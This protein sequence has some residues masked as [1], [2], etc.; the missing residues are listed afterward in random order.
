M[1]SKKARNT[2]LLSVLNHKK[3]GFIGRFTLI[4]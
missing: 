2:L 3:I 4:T 1:K